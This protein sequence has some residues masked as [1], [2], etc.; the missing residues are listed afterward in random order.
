MPEAAGGRVPRAGPYPTHGLPPDA[1]SHGK[2]GV[3]QQVQSE[4]GLLPWGG[5][6]GQARLKKGERNQSSLAN[7]PPALRTHSRATA[8]PFLPEDAHP[9][10]QIQN[11]KHTR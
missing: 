4:P 2:A 9:T 10:L 6:R 11:H 3:A 7:L 5:S 8:A 1:V